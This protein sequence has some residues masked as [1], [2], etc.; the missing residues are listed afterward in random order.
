MHEPHEV[1]LLPAVYTCRVFAFIDTLLPFDE[2]VASPPALFSSCFMPAEAA[3]K[4]TPTYIMQK[5]DIC[6]Y[7]R[8]Y[9]RR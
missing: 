8:K 9:F 2:D 5:A 6:T 7:I 1:M 3:E 4:C